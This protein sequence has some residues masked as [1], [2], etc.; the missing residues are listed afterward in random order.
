MP[1]HIRG[2][3]AAMLDYIGPE[4]GFSRR[5]VLSN[6]WLFGGLVERQF[7]ATP[8]GNAMLRTT[9]APT[10]LAAGV[11]DNR[12]RILTFR[13]GGSARLPVQEAAEREIAAIPTRAT[14]LEIPGTSPVV[15]AP[16]SSSTYSSRTPR[17]ASSAAVRAAPWLPPT[18]SS[19]PNAR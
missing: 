6:R 15:I 17:D 9:T 13:L 19:C 18:S 2:A 1:R 4:M 12:G 5:L 7:G 14:G 11:K 10:I 16:P 3:T 8:S